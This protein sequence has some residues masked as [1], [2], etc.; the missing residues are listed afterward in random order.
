MGTGQVPVVTAAVTVDQPI[1]TL[2][3]RRGFREDPEAS[4][5]QRTLISLAAHDTGASP[6]AWLYDWVRMPVSW[7]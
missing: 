5:E 6:V 3:E 4:T 1:A 7:P 2:F